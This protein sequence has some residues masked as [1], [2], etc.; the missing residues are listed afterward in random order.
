MNRFDFPPMTAIPITPQM[1][2]IDCEKLLHEAWLNSIE[3]KRKQERRNMEEMWKKLQD[4]SSYSFKPVSPTVTGG[5]SL[6][7]L[8][9]GR[10]IP[11]RLEV[12]SAGRIVKNNRR[13]SDTIAEAWSRVSAHQRMMWKREVKDRTP[14]GK[15]PR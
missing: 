10:S 5:L 6:R 1:T 8:F 14:N 7:V 3:E 13:F 9:L 15:K 4:P 2:K 12:D 11:G